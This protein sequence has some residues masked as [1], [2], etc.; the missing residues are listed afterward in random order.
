MKDLLDC[1]KSTL[2]STFVLYLKTQNYHWNCEG[3]HFYSYH[4]MFQKQ[5]EELHDSIDEIAE[6]IRMLDCYVPGSLERFQEMSVVQSE[7]RIPTAMGMIKKLISD[8]ERVI[9]LLNLTFA[10]AEKYNQQQIMDFIAGRIDAHSKHR[11]MLLA[12]SKTNRHSGNEMPI[13]Y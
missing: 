12:S 3:N 4:T 2:A 1:L 7:L 6:R 9:E 13:N 5:Y 8:H 11:W 10:A